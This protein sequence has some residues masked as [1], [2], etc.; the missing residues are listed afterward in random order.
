MDKG[1]Q[2]EIEELSHGYSE[3][4]IL[5]MGASNE[6]IVFLQSICTPRGVDVWLPED[7]TISKKYSV[8]YMQDGQRMFTGEA[9]KK[10]REMMIDE[11]ASRLMAEDRIRRSYRHRNSQ[12]W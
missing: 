9:D 1:I 3:F 7:Y 2:S 12:Y 11:T 8:L 10:G 6:L 4:K 5:K